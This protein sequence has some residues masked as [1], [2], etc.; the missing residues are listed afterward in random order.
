MGLLSFL[1][2]KSKRGY[3]YVSYSREDGNFVDRLS[4]DLRAAGIEVWR[5]IEQISPGA[6]WREALRKGIEGAEHYLYVASAH[7]IAS[8]WVDH[9]LGE[10]VRTGRRTIPLILD[11]VGLSELPDP[12]RGMQA[13]SFRDDYRRSLAELVAS[14]GGKSAPPRFTADPAPPPP[15]KSKGYVF[16][17]YAEEDAEFVGKL[18]GFLKEHGYGYWDYS[19]NDRD[20]HTHLSLEL[21]GIIRGAAATVSVLSPAWR[22]SKWTIKEYF[23]S[24]EVEVPVFLVRAGAIG[25]TLA[26]S[27]IPYIDFVGDHERGFQMLHTELQRK[28]L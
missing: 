9:E 14:L 16:L 2:P 26:I 24:E 21:E 15:Q 12:L 20:Y 11:D 27:G 7:S 25:P 13:I 8:P 19:E 3:V 1:N 18:R 17:S 22:K 4:K 28:G 6:D 5:D 23:F 10:F